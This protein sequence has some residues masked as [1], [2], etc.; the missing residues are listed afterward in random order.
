MIGKDERG[1]Q[2]N[3]NYY[4]ISSLIF[5][6]LG[7]PNLLPFSG[8][9]GGSTTGTNYQVMI[10]MS[11]MMKNIDEGTVLESFSLPQRV[12]GSSSGTKH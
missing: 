8:H 4:I 11:M 9:G 2:Q 5:L 10:V 6:L 7:L 12:R 3:A 1:K